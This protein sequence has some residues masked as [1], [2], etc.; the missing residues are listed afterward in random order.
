[1]HTQTLVSLTISLPK[2]CRDQLR[3]IVAEIN[4]QNPDQVTSVSELGREIFC[5]YLNIPI[6]DG[7]EKKGGKV[8]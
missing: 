4:L 3:K 7:C 8:M 5:E 6:T 1:M 2:S